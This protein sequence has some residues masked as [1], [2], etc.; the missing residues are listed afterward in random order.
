MI[1]HNRSQFDFFTQEVYNKLVPEDHQ[2]VK[3]DQLVDFESIFKEMSLIYSDIGRG[4]NDPV[5]M[6]KIM[7]FEVPLKID[8][9]IIV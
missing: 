6:V 5:M 9:W 8:N 4:S 2:L 3:I 7:C 1:K